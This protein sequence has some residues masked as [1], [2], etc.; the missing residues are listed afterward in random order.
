[1]SRTIYLFLCLL[2]ILSGTNS[3]ADTLTLNVT[4]VTPNQGMVRV[5]IF[6][7]SQEFPDGKS[8]LGIVVA[9]NKK[10][11]NTLLQLPPGNYAIAIFQDENGNKELD[12]NFFGI[13]KEK[14]GFSGKEVFGRPNFDDAKISTHN[15]KS[16]LIRM[17]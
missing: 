4:G 8:F 14:Y 16:V 3:I 1:M 13:P 10:M 11:L 17:K 7:S 9:P 2:F 5:G 6:N 12:K 15:T